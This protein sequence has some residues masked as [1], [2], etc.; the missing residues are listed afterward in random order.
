MDATLTLTRQAKFLA[1]HP[2]L[3]TA[4]ATDHYIVRDIAARF[5]QW[6]SL[7]EKQVALVLKLAG[8]ATQPVNPGKWVGT[9]GQRTRLTLKLEKQVECDTQWGRSYLHIFTDEE[10]NNFKWFTSNRLRN[11]CDNP[12]DVGAVVMVNATVKSHDIYNGRHQT[13]LSRVKFV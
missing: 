8:E 5:Q 7:S 13:A 12:V 4:L 3:E 9:V 11:Q 6:G 2:G 10:G 1:E